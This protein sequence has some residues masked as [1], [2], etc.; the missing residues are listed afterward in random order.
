MVSQSATILS[1]LGSWGEKP[2]TNQG[3]PALPLPL[4]GAFPLHRTSG[5]ERLKG[6]TTAILLCKEFRYDSNY[7]PLME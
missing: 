1:G 3:I 5:F 6:N 2:L 4:T 7:Q